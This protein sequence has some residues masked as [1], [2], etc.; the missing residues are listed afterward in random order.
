M[1]TKP[2]LLALLLALSGPVLAQQSD[3]V[4]SEQTSFSEAERLLWMTDQLKAVREPSVMGYAFKRG[5]T[6]EQGFEDT[7]EFTVTKV[8]PSG[9]KDGMLR[10]FSGERNFPV[11]PAED[12]DVNPVLKVYFQGDVYEMNR[13]TDP[14]GKSRERWRYF[15]R[16]IKLALAEGARVEPTTVDFGGK[17][18]P[19][20]SISFAPFVNDPKRGEFERFAGKTYKVVVA[21]TLPGYLYS[22][23]TEIPGPPGG[24]PLVI[25]HLKLTAVKPFVAKAR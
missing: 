3:A 13:L 19:G 18:H 10:F 20:K 14:A 4:A 8:K 21:D 12:T 7:V 17:T 2:T 9:L 11:P 25:E 1:T 16:R 5:G 23:E 15:Q 22:L 24:P 6:Y